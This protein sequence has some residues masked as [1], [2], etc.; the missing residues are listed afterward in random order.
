MLYSQLRGKVNTCTLKMNQVS[1]HR[2]KY[3]QGPSREREGDVALVEANSV[4]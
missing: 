1:E 4:G 2:I 3:S